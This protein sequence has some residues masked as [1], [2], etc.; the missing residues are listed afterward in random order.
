M[1]SNTIP[2]REDLGGLTGLKSEPKIQSQELNNFTE[3]A[4][5]A[6]VHDLAQM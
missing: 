6:N 4:A 1:A 2:F 3:L 5:A